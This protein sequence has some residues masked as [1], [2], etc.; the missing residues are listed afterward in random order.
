[1]TEVKTSSAT[2]L[3]SWMETAASGTAM[4][5]SSRWSMMTARARI[6]PRMWRGGVEVEAVE[7]VAAHHPVVVL[8]L[9]AVAVAKA[10][11]AVVPQ[12]GALAT[13]TVRNVVLWSL[14]PRMLA[15]SAE[16]L[17]MAVV[18]AVTVAVAVAEA[19]GVTVTMTMT[20]GVIAVAVIAVIA[21]DEGCDRSESY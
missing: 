21:A 17:E 16:P 1:M 11:V 3:H 20:T 7:A 8:L 4:K 13:G 6:V 9:L 19:V 5:Y 10:V 12:R 15:S 18:G 2:L 14:P